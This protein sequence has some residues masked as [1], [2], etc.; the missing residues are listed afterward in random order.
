MVVSTDRILCHL[1]V[2]RNCYCGLLYYFG[3]AFWSYKWLLAVFWHQQYH[4][5]TLKWFLS[6]TNILCF[7]V[8]FGWWSQ[9]KSSNWSLGFPQNS[10]VWMLQQECGYTSTIYA[11]HLNNVSYMCSSI[12]GYNDDSIF[13]LWYVASFRLDGISK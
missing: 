1:Q 7:Y 11:W 5:E 9:K 13:Y 6:L 3:H 8:G 2:R 4:W 10:Q 12:Y